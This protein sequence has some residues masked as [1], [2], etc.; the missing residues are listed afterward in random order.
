MNMILMS[1]LDLTV[2]IA[3]ITKQNIETYGMFCNDTYV[4]SLKVLVCRRHHIV[5]TM[6][7]VLR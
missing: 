1:V 7:D 4:E 5:I 3:N 2:R 6:G